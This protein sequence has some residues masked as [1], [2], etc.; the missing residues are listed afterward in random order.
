M[1]HLYFLLY[2]IAY[3]SQLCFPRELEKRFLQGATQDASVRVGQ[4]GFDG[5]GSFCLFLELPSLISIG[6][7]LLLP[8]V[9]LKILFN[10]LSS[11]GMPAI[12]H[13]V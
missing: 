1:N 9:D 10:S 7:G 11:S 12:D 2:W 5:T 3:S 13:H 4:E 6:D 8:H